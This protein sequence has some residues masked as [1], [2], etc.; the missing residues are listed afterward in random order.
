MIFYRDAS[1]QTPLVQHAA[2]LGH[3]PRRRIQLERS[4]EIV[5][6]LFEF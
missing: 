3:L 1:P 2:N 5:V 4:V 6:S